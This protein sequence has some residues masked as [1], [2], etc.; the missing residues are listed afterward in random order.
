MAHGK[1][2]VSTNLPGPS[3]MI[4]DGVTGFLV[5]PQNPSA[6]AEA[7][8]KLLDDQSLA[9]QMGESGKKRAEELFDIKK[10]VKQIERIYEELLN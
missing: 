9:R 7:I 6:L 2:V 1:P 3:E 8:V 4:V 10:N 5:P